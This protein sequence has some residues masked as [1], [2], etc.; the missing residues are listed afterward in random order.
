MNVEKLVRNLKSRE[1][2]A[3]YFE[4][5]EEAAQYLEEEIRGKK[6]VFGGS[7]TSEKLGIYERLGKNNEVFWHWRTRDAEAQKKAEFECEVYISSAN[8]IAET[9]EIFNIDGNGNRV[10]NSIYSKDA[11]YFIVGK[12]KV[13]PD[14]D[15]ALNYARNVASPLNA[16]RFN[17]ST[18]CTVDGKCHDCRSKE[19]ICRALV[20]IMAKINTVRHME[21][22]IVN[23][24]LGF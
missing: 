12:N 13:Q 5:G 3:K 10:S 18:P 6:V 8:G 4:T 15:S 22:I 11:V 21:V 7:K 14:F 2:D 1:I 23:E 19:K 9:G 24:E 20:I 17:L 16:K